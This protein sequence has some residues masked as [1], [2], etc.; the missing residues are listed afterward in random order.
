MLSTELERVLR[1]LRLSGMT[2]EIPD[3]IEQAIRD[4]IPH[5]E[6]LLMLFTDEIERRRA[7][8]LNKALSK[9]NFSNQS[10]FDDFD[11]SFNP[12]APKKL[13]VELS[14]ATF[15]GQAKPII[16]CGPTGVG[17][18]H[19][20][21]AIGRKAIRKGHSVMFYDARDLFIRLRAAQGDGTYEKK[22]RDLVALD[23]L[24]LDDLGL[25][26]LKASEAYDLYDIIRKR[27]EKRATMITSNRAVDEWGSLFPDPLIASAALDRILENA[28]VVVL[29]GRS[30][31]A[32]N[33]APK[34][35]KS[36][37]PK[38]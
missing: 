17:K 23:L 22:F 37:T 31:R 36:E 5:E 38:S 11:F 26:P 20:A 18:S 29:Q 19:L 7:N 9:A 28:E 14:S 35:P 24:I 21:Q 6:F 16:L 10:E 34:H 33:R 12:N 25:H 13:L 4:N 1:Q 8:K 32:R 30:Y 27:H 15:V 3:R 2:P